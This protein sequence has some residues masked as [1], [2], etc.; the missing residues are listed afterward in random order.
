MN[1]IVYEGCTSAVF[2]MFSI[3]VLRITECEYCCL[4]GRREV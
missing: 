1:L 3:F 4:L 2:G